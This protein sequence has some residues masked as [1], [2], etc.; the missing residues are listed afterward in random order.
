[1]GDWLADQLINPVLGWFADAVLGALTTL[2]GLLSAT[3]F[4]SPDVTTLPQ[5]SAFARTSLGVVNTCYVLAFLWVA[6]LVLGRDTLQSRVVDS[7]Q[8]GALGGP[9]L[10]GQTPP[11]LAAAAPLIPPA[12]TQSHARHPGHAHRSTPPSS[13]PSER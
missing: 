2:W 11:P 10:H 3:V 7:S 12:P 6:I 4:V 1:M 9:G 13:G 5:V 8:P